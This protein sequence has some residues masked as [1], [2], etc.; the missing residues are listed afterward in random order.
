MSQATF[1]G[2]FGTQPPLWTPLVIFRESVTLGMA[3]QQNEK[4]GANEWAVTPF[5][6]LSAMTP[7][8]GTNQAARLG[9]EGALGADHSGVTIGACPPC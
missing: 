1:R 4:V 9:F 8:T 5:T 3:Q 2:H 7:W 6:L